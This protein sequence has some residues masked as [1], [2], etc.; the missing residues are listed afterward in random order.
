MGTVLS[1]RSLRTSGVLL[2]VL[3]LVLT[4]VPGPLT[5]NAAATG[6]SSA[7]SVDP[8]HGSPRAISC[9]SASF[10]AEV[11]TNG[12]AFTYN[13]T[14]WSA[15]VRIDFSSLGEVFPVTLNSVSCATASFCAAVDQAGN[16]LMYDGTRWSPPIAI[17][18]D[19]LSSVSCPS[20]TFCAAV[21]HSGYVATY[22]GS[23]WSHPTLVDPGSAG[24]PRFVSCTS[25]SFCA[26][27]RGGGAV[28]YNGTSWSASTAIVLGPI[29]YGVSCASSAFCV[30]EG[31]YGFSGAASILFNGSTWSGAS[32]GGAGVAVSCPSATFCAAVDGFGGASTYNGTT[33]HAT[34]GLAYGFGSVSCASAT[35]CMASGVA[36]SVPVGTRGSTVSD[37]GAT[38]RYDGSTWSSPVAVD[39]IGGGAGSV[40]CPVVGFCAE[41]AAGMDASVLSNGTWSF[42]SY[43]D[44]FNV[45]VRPAVSC[46]STTYCL[47]VNNAGD[48]L[49]YNGTT[50]STPISIDGGGGLAAVSCASTTFCV[51]VSAS[52]DYVAYNGAGWSLPQA[53]D[54]GGD[55]FVAISCP[56]AAF[57]MALDYRGRSLTYNGSTWSSPANTSVGGNGGVSCPTSTF[58]IAVA[59]GA[60]T[61]YSSGA[62]SPAVNLAGAVYTMSSVS[63]ASPSFCATVDSGGFVRYFNGSVWSAGSQ[64][65][66]AGVVGSLSCPAANYC[67]A[68]DAVGNAYT[69]GAAAPAVL[70]VLSKGPTISGTH[71]VGHR[72]TCRVTYIGATSVVFHW[73]RNGK[74]VGAAKATYVL[75]AKDYKTH[76]ACTAQATSAAGS[77]AVSTSGRVLIRLGSPLALVR[78]Q[79]ATVAGTVRGGRTVKA[80]VGRWTPKATSYT[81]QWLLAGKPI[82][83]AT[84]AA[85]AIPKADKGKR[86]SVKVV[87]HRRGYG[88][89]S[90]ISKSVVVG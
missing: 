11:D 54:A 16:A 81:Y 50:W 46:V 24:A 2:G 61:T 29:M 70:P 83:H 49:T 3:A 75:T 39:P 19:I 88:N 82:R 69:Y 12:D 41:V 76:L 58:C 80:R 45:S 55:G 65:S 68:I 67:V 84:H 17:D 18:S 79:H 35:F 71:R 4:C 10:C 86:L 27:V 51:A 40:S 20:T 38:F 72:L 60:A 56:T 8:P 42:S 9:A 34:S 66:P 31:L 64:L 14:T 52:G 7:V 26:V 74:A 13:G 85:F 57:C 47:A 32:S 23:G 89:G 87:A 62:W 6:W 77:T 25:A 36:N 1:L 63:C 21:D 15:G 30:A 78:H 90:T 37:N 53:I 44:N 28:T 5:A 33:W 48:V 59:G 43:V 22:T 73:K